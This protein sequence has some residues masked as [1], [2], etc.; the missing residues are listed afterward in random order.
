[1]ATSL[2]DRSRTVQDFMKKKAL[3]YGLKW[4][5][6]SLFEK[7]PIQENISFTQFTIVSFKKMYNS[8]A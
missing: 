1:M 7:S 3:Y 2:E 8:N 5:Y 6:N 4:E